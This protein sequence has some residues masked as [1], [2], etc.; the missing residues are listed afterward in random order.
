M[1]EFI[2]RQKRF[3]SIILCIVILY[4]ISMY[5]VLSG[6]LLN[7]AFYNEVLSNKNVSYSLSD[8]P[9]IL[10]YNT[11]INMSANT[12]NNNMLPLIDGLI[13]FITQSDMTL[14]DI[15]FEENIVPQNAGTLIENHAIST[16]IPEISRIHPF[17]ITYLVPDSNSIYQYL[18]ILKQGYAIYRF[19]SSVLCFIGLLIILFSNRPC[20]K[21]R[22]ALIVNSIAICL[23]GLLLFVFNDSLLINPLSNVL[24][25]N[26]HLIKPFIQETCSLF[27]KK[28]LQI[29]L[30]FLAIA[31]LTKVQFVAKLIEG[32]SKR[33]ALILLISV[34]LI[35]VLFRNEISN[36]IT[37]AVY[38]DKTVHNVHTLDKEEGAVH[39]LTIKLKDEQTHNPVSDVQ[40]TLIKTDYSDRFIS[41][42]DK[43]GNARFILPQGEFFLYANQAT[44][45][46]GLISFE[47]VVISIN[48][49]DSSWYTFHLRKTNNKKV[50]PETQTEQIFETSDLLL[51]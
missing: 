30:L 37:R 46:E 49:P 28:I 7:S 16:K 25:I 6:T 8:A 29:S 44:V 31:Y 13:R 3:A 36:N 1:T 34:G 50:N 24:G 40:L 41:H 15:T 32:N 23:T 26:S 19:F 51:P 14:S 47:P 27:F 48:Y 45:P 21:L 22:I 35:F 5:W 11:T 10:S 18:Y 39:S 17:A 4:F 43:S 42:S 12:I 33:L 2:D 20:K 38:L 9:Q